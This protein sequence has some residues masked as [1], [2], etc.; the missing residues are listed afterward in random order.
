MP[1]HKENPPETPAEKDG[2]KR[3]RPAYCLDELIQCQYLYLFHQ[4]LFQAHVLN[5]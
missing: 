4:Y 3:R 5:F 1:V 2:E